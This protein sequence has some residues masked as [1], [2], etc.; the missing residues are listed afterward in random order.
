MPNVVE[1]IL[2]TTGFAGIEIFLNKK[3]NAKPPN[4]YTKDYSSLLMFNKKE[5]VL[6]FGAFT[7]K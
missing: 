5:M 3:N 4:I 2:L 6:L 7:I 1:A